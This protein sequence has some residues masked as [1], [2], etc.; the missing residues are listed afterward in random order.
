MRSR[1]LRRS[2]APAT[3]AERTAAGIRSRPG[4]TDDRRGPT[5]AEKPTYLGLLNGIAIAEGRA[6]DYLE[7]WLERATD[8][9]LRA[10]LRTVA[11]RE[12]E[13]SL[14]FAKRINEL[15]FEVQPTDRIPDFSEQMEIVTSDCSDYEKADA[16]GL[17]KT[18]RD[19]GEPD[20]FSGFFND[21]TIDIQTGALLGRYICEERDTTRM[22][23]ACAA[24]LK[25]K[26]DGTDGDGAS[27]RLAALESKVD[28]VCDAITQLTALVVADTAGNGTRAKTKTRADTS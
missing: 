3:I 9:D 10:T 14:A 20:I 15:G 7:A 21:T 11:Y 27:D 8:A 5:M 22:I 6:A 13:H 4:E 19:T 12:R 28:Q 24:Q 25:A 1:R 26:H 18:A 17:F 16:L 23:A 2:G